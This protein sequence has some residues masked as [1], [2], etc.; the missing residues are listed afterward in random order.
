MTTYTHA[1]A[2]AHT[3]THDSHTVGH[4]LSVNSDRSAAD[5]ASL[6]STGT[7]TEEK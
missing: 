1:R 3:H 5:C 6:S 4:P 7:L 2:H